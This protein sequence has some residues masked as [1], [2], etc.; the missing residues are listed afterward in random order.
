VDLIPFSQSGAIKKTNL[1]RWIAKNITRDIEL[2]YSGAFT[3]VDLPTRNDV[4][5]GKGRPFQHHAGNVLLQELVEANTDKYQ[6]ACQSLD[7][8]DVV[9]NVIS[10]IK[11]RS[12]RFLEKDDDGWWHEPHDVDVMDKV[13]KRFHRTITKEQSL[14]NDRAHTKSAD[15]GNAASMFL[16]QGKRPRF[17]A[18]CC[19]I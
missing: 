5:M 19:G 1:N 7:K 4:L 2:A 3:G 9:L 15:G 6:A 11:A 14:G 8:M 18:N 16:Q 17:D 10:T 12:G 13:R